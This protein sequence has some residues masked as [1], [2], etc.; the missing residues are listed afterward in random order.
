MS[1]GIFLWKMG[2]SLKVFE[3]KDIMRSYLSRR[4]EIRLPRGR[5]YRSGDQQECG[6]GN[7]DET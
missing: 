1:H 2:E 5:G 6:G 7:S 4:G 3:Q